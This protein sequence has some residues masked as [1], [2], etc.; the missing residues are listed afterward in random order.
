MATCAVHLNSPPL[1]FI[2]HK[3]RVFHSQKL[4]QNLSL[5]FMY[6]F[7]VIDS[8]NDYLF[9]VLWVFR[10]EGGHS[11]NWEFYPFVLHFKCYP[12]THRS[13]CN[14]G[15][16]WWNNFQKIFVSLNFI[17]IWLFSWFSFEIY[18][19]LAPAQLCM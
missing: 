14:L 19:E 15:I 4:P 13:A 17:A 11:E 10:T 9:E 1:C 18:R 2:L 6:F 5:F 7:Y 8:V 12:F 3:I 16:F